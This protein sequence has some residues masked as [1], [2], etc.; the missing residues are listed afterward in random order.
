MGFAILAPVTRHA[1]IPS[2]H[3][4]PYSWVRGS[5]PFG[6]DWGLQSSHRCGCGPTKG[7][8]SPFFLR[9]RY[10]SG[11]AERATGE[12]GEAP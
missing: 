5:P 2:L 10:E 3:S 7:S 9:Y 1:A 6:G 4:C 8:E 12:P 11:K